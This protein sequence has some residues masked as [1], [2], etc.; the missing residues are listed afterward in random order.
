MI[1]I[2]SQ[3]TRFGPA[4][5]V[6]IGQLFILKCFM[7]INLQLYLDE[8]KNIV[9]PFNESEIRLPDGFEDV[10]SSNTPCSVGAWK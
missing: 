4:G 6:N 2:V 9:L 1:D 10:T 7:G 5:K 3:A 8:E